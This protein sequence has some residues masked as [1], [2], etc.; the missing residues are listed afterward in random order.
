MAYYSKFVMIVVVVEC[1]LI[2]KN[3]YFMTITLNHSEV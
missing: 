2:F 3:L 1:Y